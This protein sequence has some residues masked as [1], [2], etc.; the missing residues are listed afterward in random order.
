MEE[1][2]NKLG[3]EPAFPMDYSGDGFR[4]VFGMS[5]RFYAACAAMKLG[6]TP[7]LL[8]SDMV[9]DEKGDYERLATGSYYVT[10]YTHNFAALV[11]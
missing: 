6:V 10:Q 1:N 3:Q 11:S 8:D 4:M 9:E 7:T 2:K 5:K